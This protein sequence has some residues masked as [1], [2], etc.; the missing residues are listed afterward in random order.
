MLDV[1][2]SAIEVQGQFRLPMSELRVAWT[3]TLPALFG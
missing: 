2:E 1:L 3:S